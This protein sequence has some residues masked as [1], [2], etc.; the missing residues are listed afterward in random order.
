MKLINNPATSGWCLWGTTRT[1]PATGNPQFIYLVEKPGLFQLDTN[2]SNPEALQLAIAAGVPIEQDKEVGPYVTLRWW[3][4][5]YEELSY[6]DL[7]CTLEH[8]LDDHMDWS[9]PSDEIRGQVLDFLY[10]FRQHLPMA[11]FRG[12]KNLRC[13]A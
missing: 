6:Y 5:E 9:L 7:E 12:A 11:H 4:T 2:R 13:V 8:N 10:R 1:N 3:K